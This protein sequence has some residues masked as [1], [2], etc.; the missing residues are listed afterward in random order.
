[1][2]RAVPILLLLGGCASVSGSWWGRPEIVTRPPELY[3]R[4]ETDAINAEIQC[5]TLARTTLQAQRCG[6]RR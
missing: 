4:A 3:T 2:I 6:I 1:M 5:R